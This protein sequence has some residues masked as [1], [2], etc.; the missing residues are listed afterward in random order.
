[1]S[2]VVEVTLICLS[3]FLGMFFFF[4]GLMK[5]SPL[6][7]RDI[8]MNL[9]KCFARY[10]KVVPILSQLGVRIQARHYRLTIGV[11]EMIFGLLLAWVP[12]KIKQASN[13]LLLVLTWGAIYTHVMVHD[14]TDG[15][16]L[17]R[18]RF[19]TLITSTL[20]ISSS[21]LALV[22]MP[23]FIFSGL[24]L[25]RFCLHYLMADRVERERLDV[26]KRN[27]R[28]AANETSAAPDAAT[29]VPTPAAAAAAPTGEN[30]RKKKKK[31]K[32]Q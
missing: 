4:H 26:A 30:K 7:H 29:V 11:I 8:H 2:R 27:Q 24:L 5:V 23:A 19:A 13:L 15:K 16:C 32:E 22:M 12:G 10:V 9:R 28:P 31:V 20:S 14:D 21:L 6:L 25:A 17:L 3:I 1:M 18:N